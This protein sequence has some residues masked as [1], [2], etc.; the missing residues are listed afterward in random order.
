MTET[1]LGTEVS[2][3]EI[4][5][6][7]GYFVY[8]GELGCDYQQVPVATVAA[9]TTTWLDSLA[10]TSLP[11]QYRVEASGANPVCR[12]AVSSC[13]TTPAIPRLQMNSHRL[14][15][16]GVYANGSGMLD[17][18]ETV[19]IP[20][21]LFNGG[22]A[23]ALS[24]TGHLRTVDPTQGRVIEPLANW[25]DIWFDTELESTSPHL[26]LTLFSD[27]VDC[28]ATV[29]LDLEMNADGASTR[30]KRFAFKLGESDRDFPKTANVPMSRFNTSPILSTL[31]I[32]DDT[33]IGEL[34]VSVNISHTIPGDLIVQLSS[35]LGTTV[36]LHD[37]TPGTGGI[38]TRYD[39]LTSP[40]GPGAMLDFTGESL[41]GTWTLSVQNTV[42]GGGSGTF[43]DWT[44]HVS[45]QG[46]FGCSE[47]VCAEP[48]PTQAVNGLTVDK[49]SEDLS[50]AWNGVAG[51]AGYHVLQSANPAFTAG[52]D[53]AG[54]T[55]ATSL[56][57]PGGDLSTPGLTYFQVR[58]VNACHQESP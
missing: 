26:S 39:L 24:V 56:N 10:D 57:V 53:L 42:F 48:T 31:D 20:V 5:G 38:V 36:R 52:G 15:E 45:S 8:R 51:A 58:A 25:A 40:D 49:A 14:I 19:E 46:A 33:V 55:S 18:G 23:D 34:D 32:A 30:M 12:S 4:A 7:A 50:I 9:G 3:V 47:F 27:G 22:S 41:A 2:W 28:G 16:S 1:P 43:S 29:E 21:T 35:P 44:L 54:R 13:G 17:P 6:A 11:R 37:Q